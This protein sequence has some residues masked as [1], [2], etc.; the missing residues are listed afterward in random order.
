[1][2]LVKIYLHFL[3]KITI[4]TTFLAFFVVFFFFNFSLLDLDPCGSMQ[5]WIHS[6]ATGHSMY[7]Y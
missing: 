6:P 3:Y 7:R 5:I 1:M 2:D 4:I